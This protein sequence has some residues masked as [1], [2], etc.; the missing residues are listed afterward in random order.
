MM[1]I[2]D[3]YERFL[4]M[5]VGILLVPV[6][7]ASIWI[8][9]GDDVLMINGNHSEFTDRLFTFV[10]YGGDGML[11]V[12]LIIILLFIRFSYSI[13]TVVAWLGHGLICAI[14][15]RLVFPSALRPAGVMDN[16][17]LYF[18]PGV[19]VHAH[20]SFPS[21]HT[22]T[23]F[24]LGILVALLLRRRSVLVI[25]I[26]FAM[27]VGYSRIYLLQHFLIDVAAGAIIGIVAAVVCWYL[28]ENF[29]KAEWM[30]R[31]LEIQ[32]KRSARVSTR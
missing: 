21:G 14:M 16:D 24:C 22:A 28:F 10:T 8:P 3:R 29:G 17:L 30:S 5:A 27:L 12:P 1:K 2:T 20:H 18:I 19:E 7:I 25:M 32:V 23:A 11:F 15:K 13:A 4:L 6:L 9:K 26:T 31:R